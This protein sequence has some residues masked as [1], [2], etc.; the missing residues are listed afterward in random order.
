MEGFSGAAR[1]QAP[2]PGMCLV[3]MTSQ[4]PPGPHAGFTREAF[5]SGVTLRDTRARILVS[6]QLAATPRA[7]ERRGQETPFRR[8]ADHRY[9]ERFPLPASGPGSP[10]TLIR[11]TRAMRAT[12]ARS[13]VRIR[14][15]E[16]SNAESNA[17]KTRLPE[18][19]SM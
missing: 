6:N 16:P 4:H 11:S 5:A 13:R 7:L 8:F 15:R 12:I 2:S 18:L 9:S 14:N 10:P 17:C 19:G 3:V 1:G